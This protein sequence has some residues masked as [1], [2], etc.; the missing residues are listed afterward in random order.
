MPI[1]YSASA[2]ATKAGNNSTLQIAEANNAPFQGMSLPELQ[3]EVEDTDVFSPGMVDLFKYDSNYKIINGGLAN[4]KLNKSAKTATITIRKNARWSNGAQVTAKDAEYPYEVIGSPDSTSS[5]YSADMNTIDGMDAFHNGKA[6]TISGIQFPN[7]PQGKTLVIHFSRI[8]PAMQYDG[9]DFMWN[10]IDPYEQIKNVKISKLG[11]ASAVRN[12]P[13]FAGPYK[14]TKIVHGESTTW[15][16]NKYYYGP[17]PH[18]QHI[19]IQ[20]VSTNTVVA[21]LQSS[22]YD[23]AYNT[24]SSQMTKVKSLKNVSLVGSPA[25]YYNYFGFNLGYWDAKNNKNVMYKNTKMGNKNLRQAMMYALDLDSIFKKLGNGVSWRANTLIPPAYKGYWDSKNPGFPYDINK[26]N[27]LLDQ[28][29]YKKKG[30]WRV[31]P[32]GKPLVIYFGVA[33]GGSTVNARYQYYLQQWHKIG[34]NVQFATGR[35]MDTNRFFNITGKAKQNQIDVY[36][37]GWSLFHEPTPTSL[38]G[39]DAAFNMGHFVTSENTSLLNSLN[40]N[41]AWNLNY[42]QQQFKKWQKY[43]NDQAAYTPENFSLNVTPVNHRVKNYSQAASDAED[44]WSNLELTQASP[45]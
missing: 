21:G 24:P 9:N 40:S 31:Q 26:A 41:K 15:V 14:L 42:R 19:T 45:K 32:N 28:A 30:K 3:D 44:F 22:K 38:Y 37:T 33:D 1:S 23:F 10:N 11:S 29:G 12:T 2:P 25:F 34:L 39:V 5:Q 6:K 4:L 17:K 13:I 18:I 27:Q 36:E 43:M 7:G 16:P 35:P 20:V 8:V